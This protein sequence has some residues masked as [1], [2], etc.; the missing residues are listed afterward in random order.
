MY[1]LQ[2]RNKNNFLFS[3][4]ISSQSADIS[5]RNEQISYAT[6]YPHTRIMN[7]MTTKTNS[8]VSREITNELIQK[9]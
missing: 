5:A 4:T 7:E 1:F 6:S 9:K 2:T 3:A 8:A